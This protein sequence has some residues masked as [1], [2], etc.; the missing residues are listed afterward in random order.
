MTFASSGAH[1]RALVRDGEVER[2]QAV[3]IST[4][5]R[6]VEVDG[7]TVH[8]LAEYAV[9]TPVVAFDVTSMTLV[10]SSGGDRRKLIDRLALYSRRLSLADVTA[11]SR[12]VK[13]RRLVLEARGTSAPDLEEWE[14]LIAR[15]GSSWFAARASTAALLAPAIED[16]FA[17]MAPQSQP[18]KVVFHH[19]APEDVS[20][21]RAALGEKR[22]YDRGHRSDAIGRHK[23]DLRIVMGGR[24]VRVIG[25]QG[26][27][28]AIVLAL[29]LAELKLLQLMRGTTPILL[30][31]D[32]SSELDAKRTER[33]LST[34]RDADAQ[35][36]LTTTRP[37]LIARNHLWDRADRHDFCVSSGEVCA[38]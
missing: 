7:N 11:Y 30:L 36:L 28:R 38:V 5:G 12:A 20:S 37:E 22:D 15:H 34:V 23:D 17:A 6:V 18:L 21:F 3:G 9:L 31:D 24:D 35:V 16:I 29:K 13:T 2:E 33:F 10:S 8:R 25:S 26:E 32:V 14:E 1:V 4:G 27:R 19:G